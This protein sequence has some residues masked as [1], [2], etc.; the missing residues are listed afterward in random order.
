MLS[1]LH[2]CSHYG[3]IHQ[4]CCRS[5]CDFGLPANVI[6]S[7][8]KDRLNKSLELRGSFAVELDNIGFF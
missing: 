8:T 5:G 4:P 3:I 6:V 2:C 7:I 1:V